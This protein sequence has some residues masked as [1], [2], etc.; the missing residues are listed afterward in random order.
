MTFG[1]LNINLTFVGKKDNKMRQLN[2]NNNF[3]NNLMNNSSKMG[4]L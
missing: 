3:F 2:N 4:R 1:D